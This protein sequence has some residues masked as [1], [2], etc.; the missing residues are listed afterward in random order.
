MDKIVGRCQFL[1]DWNDWDDS[2]HKDEAQIARQG[3]AM[4]YPFTF[5][6]N[7]KQ[8][9]ARFSSTTDLPYYDT[10]L[11]SC[12]CYDFQERHLPCKHIYRLAVELGIIE[13]I[14]RPSFDKEKLQ[15]IKNSEDIDSTPDQVKRQ[16]SAA[17]C[18]ILSI[19]YAAGTGVFAGSGKTPYETTVNTCTCRDYFVRRL[20]C[21]HIY[22]MRM[23]MS[24]KS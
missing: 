10:T 3:R 20:P 18:K 17:K 4:N 13:I 9:N 8:K 7:K 21:K 12:T 16:K 1:S 24:K 11:S 5:K 19:D 14:R 6:V 23:E 2:I 22:R 15:E